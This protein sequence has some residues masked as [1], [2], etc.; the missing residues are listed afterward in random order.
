M[1]SLAQGLF[2]S[3]LSPNWT[4]LVQQTHLIIGIFAGGN[5]REIP[6]AR[7][8]QECQRNERTQIANGAEQSDRAHKTQM[9]S[10][11]ANQG[12]AQR[13]N[14]LADVVR[15]SHAGS[16]NL[17][18]EQLRQHRSN[19]GKCTIHADAHRKPQRCQYPRVHW[20]EQVTTRQQ[21]GA[22]TK[23]CRGESTTQ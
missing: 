20:N 2:R 4:C 22:E 18:W 21:H 5:T 14:R 8:R 16:S 1:K 13:S 7:L 17:S 15:E 10:N 9:L 6:T 23:R 12:D 11:S 19:S 3:V